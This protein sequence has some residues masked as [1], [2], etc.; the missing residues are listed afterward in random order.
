MTTKER[1]IKEK[2]DKRKKE[3]LTANKFQQFLET[4]KGKVDNEVL[5]KAL[6]NTDLVNAATRKSHNSID[7]G[8]KCGI[9]VS[10]ETLDQLAFIE[11][12]LTRTG[13]KVNRNA[14]YREGIA[15]IHAKYIVLD[16]KRIV[17]RKKKRRERSSA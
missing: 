12:Y 13:Q 8:K 1:E 17:K 4:I 16:K 15:L 6:E 3:S 9:Y 7:G 5:M 2:K 11:K 10:G 14:L